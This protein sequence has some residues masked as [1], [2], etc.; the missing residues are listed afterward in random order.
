MHLE[1]KVYTKAERTRP[2]RLWD[3]WKPWTVVGAGAALAVGGGVLHLQSRRNY[4]GFDRGVEACARP[5]SEGCKP[6][7]E[8]AGM[9]T[10]GDTLRRAA[11]GTW[12]ASGAALATGAVLLYVNRPQQQIVDVGENGQLLAVTPLV[13]SGTHGVLA[14]FSF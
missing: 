5:Q 4:V 11:V 1:I 3:T 12:I 13:G 10:R 9:R 2:V 6:S 7:S 14:S 8:L